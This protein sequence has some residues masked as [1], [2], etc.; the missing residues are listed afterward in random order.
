VEFAPQPAL[1]TSTVAEPCVDFAADSSADRRIVTEG[2]SVEPPAC[3]F[4]TCFEE[5]RN[6]TSA[7]VVQIKINL[8]ETYKTMFLSKM[9][10]ALLGCLISI[11]FC[12][13]S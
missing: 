3:V 10:L 4:E 2:W 11:G 9:C 13:Q 8:S 12:S 7:E 1:E 6:Q 5:V